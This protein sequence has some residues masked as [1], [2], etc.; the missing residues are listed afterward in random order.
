MECET[1]NKISR[2]T[3]GTVGNIL[4]EDKKKAYDAFIKFNGYCFFMAIIIAG[5]FNLVFGSINRQCSGCAKG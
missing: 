5:P 3:V 4:I 1:T 2:A